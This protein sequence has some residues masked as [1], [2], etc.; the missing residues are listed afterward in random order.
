MTRTT[1]L[2]LALGA[3][4]CATAA[5]VRTPDLCRATRAGRTHET[6][7]PAPDDVLVFHEITFDVPG[8]RERFVPAFLGERL[9]T[10]IRGDGKLPAVD[11][12]E[13]LTTALYPAP[14][15][16]RLV[17]LADGNVADEEVLEQDGRHLRYLVTNYSSPEAGPIAYGIGELTFEPGSGATEATHVRW[18]YGFKLRSDRFPGYLGGLGRS[19]F[20]S[21][22][23]ESDYAP[24]M[25]HQARDIRAFAERIVA[26]AALPRPPAGER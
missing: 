15:S 7:R 12:T 4:G 22:F 13:A 19:L 11:H 9:S 17:C 2:F 23:L 1:L 5:P 18:R 24:F 10:F 25:E 16:L 26:D 14:G 20:R 6:V 21:N 3:A 8:A